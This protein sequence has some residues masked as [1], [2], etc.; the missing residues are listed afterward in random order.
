M[1]VRTLLL[2]QH[3]LVHSNAV[4]EAGVSQLLPDSVWDRLDHA[5]VRMQLPGHNSLAWL[6]WH[7][8]R[9]ED[10]SV[11]RLVRGTP[12]VLDRDGWLQRLEVDVRYPGTGM[13]EED[14]ADLSRRINIKALHAYRDAVGRETR[15]WIESSELRGL[16]HI[17]E[18]ASERV[19]AS[20]NYPPAVAE[21]M[22]RA[23]LFEGR[24]A[25][26]YLV[27][28]PLLHSALHLGECIH[29]IETL[30]VPIYPNNPAE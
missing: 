8:A 4:G 1:D 16:D 27:R 20:G 15:S 18:D 29:V 2:A 30:G 6:L 19:A 21:A 10:A 12:E 17:V 23:G 22:T 5:Q 9:S 13:S 14:V 3:S 28:G 7:I 26:S 11:N 24:T 25:A